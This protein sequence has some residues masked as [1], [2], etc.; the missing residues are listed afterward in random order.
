MFLGGNK[1]ADAYD[2]IDL[3]VSLARGNWTLAAGVANATNE[4]GVMSVTGA[5]AGVGAF[6]Q[7]FLQ[8]P[9]TMTVSLRYDY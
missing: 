6:A 4:K 7:Y 5:P 1:P 2:T 3:G 9:R 8:R